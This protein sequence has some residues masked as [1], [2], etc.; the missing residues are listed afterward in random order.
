MRPSKRTSILEAA[1]R[2]AERDGVT[3][4]T[5]ESV[6]EAADLTKGGLMYHFPTKEALL[7]GIQQH[8]AQAW[9]SEMVAACGKSADQATPEEKLAAY[10]QV[11]TQSA[12]SADLASCST[13]PGTRRPRCPGSR[14]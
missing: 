5:L 8:V 7:L 4:V 9:E 13:S 3:G 12:S 11:A 10:A 6:A 1:I 2:V 14:W